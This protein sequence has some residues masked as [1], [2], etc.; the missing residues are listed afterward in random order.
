LVLIIIQIVGTL[1]GF[2]MTLQRSLFSGL[3]VFF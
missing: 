1:V 2:T 3:P